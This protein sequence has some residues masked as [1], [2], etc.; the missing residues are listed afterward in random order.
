LRSAPL[1]VDLVFHSE[2]LALDNDR[3][4]VVQDAV[5][6]GGRQ[7]AVVVEDLRPVFVRAVGC[8]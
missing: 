5:E 4:G 6:D 1:H 8:D 2:A 7:G 3:F